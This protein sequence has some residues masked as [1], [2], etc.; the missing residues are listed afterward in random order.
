M[1]RSSFLVTLSIDFR[2][3]PYACF[4]CCT[5]PSRS[6]QNILI[7]AADHLI[8]RSY[9][10]K[11]LPSRPSACHRPETHFRVWPAFGSPLIKPRNEMPTQRCSA[12]VSGT[13]GF[14]TAYKTGK[15]YTTLTNYTTYSKR[16]TD[17]AHVSRDNE[18]NKKSHKVSQIFH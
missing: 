18:T 10:T 12:G 15:S 14:G 17:L 4:I 3:R 2:S 11:F 7:S 5:E 8:N 1:T 13:V 9:K 6:D 16:M